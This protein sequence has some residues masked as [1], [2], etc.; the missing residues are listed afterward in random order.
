MTHGDLRQHNYRHDH[1]HHKYYDRQQRFDHHDHRVKQAALALSRWR[2]S[3]H[4]VQQHRIHLHSVHHRSRW[5][6][7]LE[8][9]VSECA[10]YDNNP[11]WQQRFD[12]ILMLAHHVLRRSSGSAN[13]GWMPRA[14]CGHASSAATRSPATG[15]LW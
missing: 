13:H 4:Q 3:I 5:E 14:L 12:N 7:N 9:Y 1:L 10:I 11:Y 8:T 2:V 15:S 6:Y